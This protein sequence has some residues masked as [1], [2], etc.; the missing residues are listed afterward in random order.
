M[1]ALIE[2]YDFDSVVKPGMPVILDISWPEELEG[3]YKSS[4]Y[5]YSMEA[6]RMRIA[7]P[8]LK[9]RLIPLPKG[10]RAYVKIV[11]RGSL[12]VFQGTVLWSGM[13][14]EDNLPSTVITIPEKVRKVQRRRYIRIPIRLV[15]KYRREDE[16]EY[17]TFSTMDFSA[18]GMLIVVG[19]QLKAGE[20]IFVTMKLKPGL[21]LKEQPAKVKR[22][23][24]FD[25]E[26]LQRFYGVE[27]LDVDLNLEKKLVRFVMEKE[28]EYRK[29]GIIY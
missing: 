19:E 1:P 7:M 16:D 13:W 3:E 5:D 9:G 18:G 27:F 22:E 20:I 15:G 2:Y 11:D 6:K 12:Y 29:K 26:T 28:I 23:A 8:S 10:T 17:H 24:G 14:K 25:R 4:V 21:E